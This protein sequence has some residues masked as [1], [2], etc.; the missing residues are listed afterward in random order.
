MIK[1]SLRTEA[2]V[3][4]NTKVLGRERMSTFFFIYLLKLGVAILL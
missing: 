2:T 3:F 1:R 4:S